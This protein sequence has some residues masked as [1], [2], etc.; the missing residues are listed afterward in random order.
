MLSGEFPGYR[1]QSLKLLK[2]IRA[3]IGDMI[4]VTKNRESWEGILIPRSESGDE[5]HVVIKMKSGYNVGVQIDASTL[6]EKVGTGIKPKFT[7]P[8]LPKQKTSLPNVAIVS[9]GGTI[10]SRVD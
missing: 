4:R 2:S 1:G 8:P 7:I 3:E 6:V 5:Y 9:T 10:A